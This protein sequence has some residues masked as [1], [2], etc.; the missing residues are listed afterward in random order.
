MAAQLGVARST[1]SG[2][3]AASAP[4]GLPPEV[5]ACLASPVG[6]CWLHQLVVVMHLII[7]LRA[8][9]GVR[10]VCECLELSGLL[11]VVGAA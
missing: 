8:C 4:E 2:W 11:E 9:A 1:P 6:A 7:T 5:A 3:C 10:L